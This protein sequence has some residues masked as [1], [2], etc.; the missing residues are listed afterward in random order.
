MEFVT[1]TD[2]CLHT[3]KDLGTLAAKKMEDVQ[4]KWQ[5]F[6]RVIC[7]KNTLYRHN[8]G[9]KVEEVLIEC[10]KDSASMEESKIRCLFS[11]EHIN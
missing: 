3:L 7:N 4:K 10:F 5:S 11:K 9:K 6:A 1:M 8:I 2:L